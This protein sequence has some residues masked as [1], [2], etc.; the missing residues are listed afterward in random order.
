MLC[1]SV[2]FLSAFGMYCRFSETLRQDPLYTLCDPKRISNLTRLLNGESCIECLQIIYY[3]VCTKCS[4]V[5]QEMSFL[6]P[7]GYFASLETWA[8]VKNDHL[9]PSRILELVEHSDRVLGTG[10]VLRTDRAALLSC[11]RSRQPAVFPAGI[12]HPGKEWQVC[13]G[14][15]GTTCGSLYHWPCRKKGDWVQKGPLPLGAF[16]S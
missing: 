16:S 14:A 11:T 4:P 15:A 12:L 9:V 13:A 5:P 1:C 2:H 3:T 10:D 7:V 8:P 6:V